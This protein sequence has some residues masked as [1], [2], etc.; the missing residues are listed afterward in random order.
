MTDPF[1]T[2]SG[3]GGAPAP[4]T[5]TAEDDDATTLLQRALDLVA[6]A[7]AMPLSSSVLVS[8]DELSDLLAAVSERLPD[9]LRQARW[10]LR[11]RDE[12]L[13]ERRREADALMD[14]VRAQ[15]EHMV[16]RAEVVRQAH[17]TAQRILDEANEESRRMRHEAEDYCDQ[18]LAG[19]EIVLERV[20]RTVKAGRQKLQATTPAARS[21]SIPVDGAEEGRGGDAG[22]FDQDM[23]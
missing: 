14:E 10:L 9:E 13:A 19:M 15:A 6:S 22:F 2:L 3:D 7:K 11:E 1:E 12:V 17:Q 16:S 21:D 5:G 23:S 20:M 8:R 18:R 4:E